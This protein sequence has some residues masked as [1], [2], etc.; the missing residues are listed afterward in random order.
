VSICLPT[1]LSARPA[2][3]LLDELVSSE[4]ADAHPGFDGGDA[5]ADQHVRLAGAGR[6]DQAGV[7]GRA[8][9]FEAGEVVEARPWDRGD[10]ELEVLEPFRLRKAGLAHPVAQV[11]LVTGGDLRLDQGAQQLFGQPALRLG[12]DEQLGGELAHLRE[13]EPLQPLLEIRGEHNRGAA[14]WTASSA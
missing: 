13:L 4:V 1:L 8:D 2:V 12:G 3:E 9:P 10:G 5:A 7:A 6:A 14:H 11:G